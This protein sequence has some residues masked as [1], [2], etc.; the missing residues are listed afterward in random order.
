[1]SF[2]LV[3]KIEDPEGGYILLIG[4]IEANTYSYYAPNQHQD[5]FFQHLFS[6]VVTQVEGTLIMGGD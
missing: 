6:D 1:M 5:T 3:R 2:S 4:N